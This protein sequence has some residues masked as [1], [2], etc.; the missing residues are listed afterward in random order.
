MIIRTTSAVTALLLLIGA[1]AMAQV[2]SEPNAHHYQGGPKTG[3]PHLTTHPKSSAN[4]KYI[5]KGQ[6]SSHRYQGGPKS[7]N[8]QS[9]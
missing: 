1:P 6:G 3:V 2:A 4:A 9:K 7:E 5:K 8:H